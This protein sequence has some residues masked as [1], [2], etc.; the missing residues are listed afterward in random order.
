[1]VPSQAES[2]R[3]N[4]GCQHCSMHSISRQQLKQE[5]NKREF[6][7]DINPRP[8]LPTARARSLSLSLLKGSPSHQRRYQRTPILKNTER[9][10]VSREREYASTR[11]P[12]P[13]QNLPPIPRLPP[14][15]LHPPIPLIRQQ[16]PHPR[17]ILRVRTNRQTPQT[18]LIATMSLRHGKHPR[19]DPQSSMRGIHGCQGDVEGWEGE[20]G[21][22]AAAGEEKAVDSIVIAG[23]LGRVWI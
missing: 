21:V 20:L 12:P 17:E 14:P 19:E 16:P 3:N 22:L 2:N 18:H 10:T 4:T 23:R 15:N 8:T 9:V 13:H 7:K 11:N 1:M 6:I 5:K